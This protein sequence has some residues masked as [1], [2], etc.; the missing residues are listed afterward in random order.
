MWFP[1]TSTVG[2]LRQ[3]MTDCK[4]YWYSPFKW[5]GL[6]QNMKYMVLGVSWTYSVVNVLLWFRL[7]WFGYL[8]IGHNYNILTTF[9][10]HHNFKSLVGRDLHGFV[11]H[12]RHTNIKKSYITSIYFHP[13]YHPFKGRS[14]PFHFRFLIWWY[15]GIAFLFYGCELADSAICHGRHLGN[16]G[17][18]TNAI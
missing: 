8:L 7:T 9:K 18:S 11:G 2:Y 16:W 5:E 12:L 17:V 15:F 4:G 10:Q 13:S 6:N 3:Q 1:G 14:F